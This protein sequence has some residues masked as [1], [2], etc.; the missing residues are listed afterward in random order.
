MATLTFTD[1]SRAGSFLLSEAPGTLSRE[2]ITILSGQ[3]LAP[4]TLLGKITASG[5]YVAYDEA[6]ADDGRRVAVGVL[7]YACDASDG[8]TDAVAIVR[9]AEVAEARLTGLDANGKADLAALNIF[10]RS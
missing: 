9:Q 7:L 4:G 10:C 8:D 5:K 6:G 3:T 2:S 1:V